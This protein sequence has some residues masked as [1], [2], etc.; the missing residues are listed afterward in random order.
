MKNTVLA[1]LTLAALVSPPL[2]ADVILEGDKGVRGEVCFV[3]LDKFPELEFYLVALPKWENQWSVTKVEEG[4][5]MTYYKLLGPSL[6][7][8]PKGTDISAEGLAN[9]SH[10]W[11]HRSDV[12]IDL[13]STVS[14]GDPT[15][16]IL[17]SYIILEVTDGEI[18]IS[19]AQREAFDADGELIGGACCCC[20]SPLCLSLGAGL[21]ILVLLVRRARKKKSAA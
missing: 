14:T 8:V 16:R 9:L 20:C 17:D 5:A 19:E 18:K 2:Q 10:D 21:V 1:L 4:S 11:P 3:G 6:C 13:A 7:A 15:V 12:E